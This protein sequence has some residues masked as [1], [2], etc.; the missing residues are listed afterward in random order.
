MSTHWTTLIGDLNQKEFQA[1]IAEIMPARVDLHRMNEYL[2][3]DVTVGMFVDAGLYN[4]R[5]KLD[6]VH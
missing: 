1:S 2:H 6:L 4:T 5:N 3:T